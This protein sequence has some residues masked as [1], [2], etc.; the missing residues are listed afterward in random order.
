[1]RW[2]AG[3]AFAAIALSALVPAAI[4]AIAAANLFTRNVYKEYLRPDASPAEEARSSKVVSVVVKAGAVAV[5]LFL[6]PEFSI[7]LQ[8]IGGVI[9]L[10]TLP[11][12]LSGLSRWRPRWGALLAGWATGTIAGLWMVYVTPSVDARTGRTV[13]EHWGGAQ[14]ALS[15][16]GP[17][18]KLTVYAGI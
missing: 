8:L 10:Q 11:T 14:F 3:V 17:D 1:P 7:D 2:F 16:L 12:L 9:V 6:R 13:H 18:T 5:I 15:H 4:M